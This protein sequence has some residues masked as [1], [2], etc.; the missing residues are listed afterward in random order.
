MP[1]LNRHE[2]GGSMVNILANLQRLDAHACEGCA[3]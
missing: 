2:G 3:P 1:L